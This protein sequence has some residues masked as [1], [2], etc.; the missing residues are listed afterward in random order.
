VGGD[1]GEGETKSF[2]PPPPSPS[3]IER[4][5]GEKIQKIKERRDCLDCRVW[6]VE[7]GLEKHFWVKREKFRKEAV[8]F[9][10]IISILFVLSLM[11]VIP[12]LAADFPPRRSRSSYPGQ[13][14]G[15]QTLSFGL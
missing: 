15:Q 3:P 9:K 7:C 6:N 11:L 8:M 1:E 12:V 13:Q 14:E 4:G 5:R 10:R 2:D